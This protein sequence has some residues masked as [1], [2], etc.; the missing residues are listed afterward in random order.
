[1]RGLP[2]RQTPRHRRPRHCRCERDFFIVNLL[3]RVHLIIQKI[4]WTGLAPWKF[5]LPFPGS[6]NSRFLGVLADIARGA[7]SDSV[8]AGVSGRRV[9][10]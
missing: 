8:V 10:H 6:L 7:V 3:V 5:E 1:M 4:W 9:V 2:H